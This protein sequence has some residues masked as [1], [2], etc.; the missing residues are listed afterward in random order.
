M[1]IPDL[2]Q[3]QV[4]VKVH[5]SVQP[6]L[7]PDHT[8]PSG[9]GTALTAAL[10]VASLPGFQVL[11]MFPATAE[12]RRLT[13]EARLL[14]EDALVKAGHE[15]QIRVS[16][17]DRHLKGRVRWT[18]SVASQNDS[19]SSDVRVY[20]TMISVL[21]SEDTLKPGISAEVT[22]FV[23][24]R[25]KVVR[26]PIHSVLEVGRERFCYVK[27]GNGIER[28]VLETGLTNNWFIEIRNG[29]SEGE[30]VVQNPRQLAE[31]RGDLSATAA[32]ERD[33]QK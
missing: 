13:A 27:N 25:E 32:A 4:R 22:I 17:L 33:D 21:D 12:I 18:S 14:Q 1:Q 16:S 2:R 9:Q 28:R 24:E 11:T 6:R 26:L 19:I 15:A 3:M 31:Q 8:A 10:T 29:L 5:E 30:L 20:P 7:R 23:D